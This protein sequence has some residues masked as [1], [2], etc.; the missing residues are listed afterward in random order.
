MFHVS[1]DL[2]NI[3]IVGRVLTK[4]TALIAQVRPIYDM[5]QSKCGS[6]SK[7]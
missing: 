2:E 1:L 3:S 5:L 7:K 4:S 6:Y